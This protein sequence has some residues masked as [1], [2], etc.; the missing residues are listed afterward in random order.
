MVACE[1]E[2]EECWSCLRCGGEVTAVDREV[3]VVHVEEE[4]EEEEGGGT[5]VELE[6]GEGE[7]SNPMEE[8]SVSNII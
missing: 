3:V 8:V 6:D 7:D 5:K 2:G 1:E 4:K